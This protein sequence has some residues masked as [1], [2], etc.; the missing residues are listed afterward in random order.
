MTAIRIADSPA[1][2]HNGAGPAIAAQGM[3]RHQADNASGTILG[4]K[5][6]DGPDKRTNCET[7]G[8]SNYGNRRRSVAQPEV[9]VREPWKT[10]MIP[11]RIVS[12]AF[13]DARE[14]FGHTPKPGRPKTHPRARRRTA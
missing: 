8:S 6:M 7:I 10:E 11:R 14:Y 9:I 13:L 5:R 2:P 1:G 3:V 4:P 12:E